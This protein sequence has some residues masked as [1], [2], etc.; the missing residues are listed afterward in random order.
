MKKYIVIYRV[1][2]CT[3]VDFVP[4]ERRYRRFYHAGGY[5]IVSSIGDVLYGVIILYIYEK[6]SGSICC[7]FSLRLPDIRS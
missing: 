4:F 3:M 7:S 5:A 6:A 2:F 1:A